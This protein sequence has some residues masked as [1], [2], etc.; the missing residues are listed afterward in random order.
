MSMPPTPTPSHN[1]QPE[2]THA[3]QYINRIKTRFADEPETYKQFL[4]ILQMYQK[5]QR[6]LQDVSHSL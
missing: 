1:P 4:E 6:V 5:E 2:F 3:I